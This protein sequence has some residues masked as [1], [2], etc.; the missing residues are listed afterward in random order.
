MLQ[1]LVARSDYCVCLRW[2]IWVNAEY[3][4]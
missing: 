2:V 4:V 1:I 3:P